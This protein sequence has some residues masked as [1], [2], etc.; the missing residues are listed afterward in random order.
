M[1]HSLFV[2]ASCM[3]HICIARHSTSFERFVLAQ[4]AYM[5]LTSLSGD[6][7]KKHLTGFFKRGQC[8]LML[9]AL[10]FAC[11]SGLFYRIFCL[12]LL[13]LIATLLA[14]CFAIQNHSEL[15]PALPAAMSAICQLC[16]T[17]VEPR[18]G[19]YDL[20]RKNCN[21]FSDCALYFLL[22][23]SLQCCSMFC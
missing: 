8:W 22:D 10:L 7:M 15:V 14:L 1:I 9:P 23:C 2:S 18:A 11:F 21:S 4:V 3:I 12:I 16:V 13:L 20:L 17:L 5:G 19:S 6:A